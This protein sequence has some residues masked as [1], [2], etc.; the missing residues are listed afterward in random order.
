MREPER[1]PIVIIGGGQAGL[2][3]GYHLA[4][5]GLPF[6]ILEAN[7]RVG[8]SWRA[9]WDS[10][11]LFTPAR[12]DG[13]AGLPFPAGPNQFPTKD[14]M[15]DYLEG[16]AKRFQLPVRTGVR[17]T[18]LSRRGDRYL[19][20]AGDSAF[21]ADHVVVAMAT[22]QRPRVP[23]FARDLDPAVVQLH[24]RDYRNLSQLQSGGVLIV[25]AGNS[26]AEIALETARGG[27]AT[28]VSGRDTGGVPFRLDSLVGRLLV[29]FVFRVVF[30]RLLTMSTPLGRKAR[31]AIVAK[32]GPLIRVKHRDLAAA[33]VER[34]A[35][36]TGVENGRP[37][38]EG[39]R[40]LDVTNV[41]WC[42]GFDPGFSWIDLPVFGNDGEPT[43]QRGIVPGEPGLYFVGLHFLYALSST[44]IH[45]VGRDAEH[46]AKAI[47]T[48]NARG[49]ISLVM[50]TSRRSSLAST[51]ALRD[52]P[53]HSRPR[54][55]PASRG[56]IRMTNSLGDSSVDN[57]STAAV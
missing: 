30:H 15:A 24:S 56:A 6:V 8:D 33:G 53:Q 37:V 9:R 45:G 39:G 19:I 21:E 17:V 51:S 38:L 34:V 42:T 13:I 52:A 35:R 4:R 11:R 3:V 41:I 14:E 12:F 40:V 43:H 36:T 57:D 2:S 44:M 27:H 25:G 28:W 55:A 1:I 47:A 50:T 20:E 18:R 31:P 46:V 29:P 54:S 49:Q 26:G 32:G 16:H 22:F 5:Q 7:E 48:R 23:S 10:L